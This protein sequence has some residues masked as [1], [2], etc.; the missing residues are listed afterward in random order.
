MIGERSIGNLRLAIG[1][2]RQL[3]AQSCLN[4]II[5]ADFLLR[6]RNRMQQ[7]REELTE[8]AKFENRRIRYGLF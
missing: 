2:Q 8:R 1:W 6:R 4:W 5:E 3:F 7:R